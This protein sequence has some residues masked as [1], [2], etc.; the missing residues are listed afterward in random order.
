MLPKMAV[1]MGLVVSSLALAQDD[2]VIHRSNASKG[3]ETQQFTISRQMENVTVHYYAA[4]CVHGDG[5]SP[6]GAEIHIAAEGGNFSRTLRHTEAAKPSVNE[7]VHTEGPFWFPPGRYSY[8]ISG[9]GQGSDL[10]ATAACIGQGEA[11][12]PNPFAG[13]TT[14]C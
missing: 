14:S 10:K 2:E 1:A 11:C 7:V 3:P 13:T 9:I 12:G 6:I 8:T 4:H 5:G